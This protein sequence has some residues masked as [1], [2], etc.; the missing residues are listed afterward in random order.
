M[1]IIFFWSD[2][3]FWTL[4][5]RLLLLLH[6]AQGNEDN[7]RIRNHHEG[8]RKPDRDQHRW[9]CT[10]LSLHLCCSGNVFLVPGH[11]N[12]VSFDESRAS[13]SV[14]GTDVFPWCDAGKKQGRNEGEEMRSREKGWNSWVWF[15]DLTVIHPLT[16]HTWLP[17]SPLFSSLTILIPSLLSISLLLHLHT[18]SGLW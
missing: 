2:T 18:P 9:W 11:E 10:L 13:Q 5:L 14:S 6:D 8:Q 15:R 16:P 1:I 3:H 7:I 17:A 4:F 12:V